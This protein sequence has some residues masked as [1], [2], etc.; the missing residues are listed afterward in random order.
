ME[1]IGGISPMVSAG[2]ED[3]AIH[4]AAARTSALG[5]NDPVALD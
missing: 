5:K 1:R 3:M 2:A 4:G